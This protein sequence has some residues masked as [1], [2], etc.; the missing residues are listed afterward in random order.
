MILWS[1]SR[2][3]EGLVRVRLWRADE[4]RW[5]GSLMKCLDD[6]IDRLNNYFKVSRST[7]L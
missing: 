7:T 5:V 2:A 4:T 6:M 3:T 1:E